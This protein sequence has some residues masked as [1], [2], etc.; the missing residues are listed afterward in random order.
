MSGKKREK[1]QYPGVFFRKEKDG[2]KAFYILYRKGGRESKLIEEPVG[3]SSTGMTPAKAKNIRADRIR[4]IEC[5]NKENREKLKLESNSSQSI[6]NL[7]CLWDKYF[8]LNSEKSDIKKDLSLLRHVED[9]LE[10]NVEEIT[11]YDIDI[12]I[13]NLKN[14]KSS[15]SSE[16]DP[17][18]LSLSTI[19]HV[20][21]LIRRLINFGIKRNLCKKPENLSIEIPHVDNEKTEMLS[22]EEMKRYL[23]ALDEEPDQDA[24]ALIR[25][26]MVT[27]MRKGALLGLKWS[28]C[29][30]EKRTI[31]LQGEYAKKGRTEYIPMNDSAK[32][33]LESINNRNSEYVFPG[34]DGKKRNDYRRIARRV[35]KKAG[36]PEDFRPLHGLRHNFASTLASSGEVELYIIQKLL[37]H[38]SPQMTQRYAHLRDEALMEASNKFTETFKK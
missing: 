35:K 19:A 21:E 32:I 16:D 2:T 4:G 15:R 36:L 33:I 14:K 31:C 18:N 7:K 28:D 26:A 38:S 8:D 11:T 1:T 3:K 17:H 25:L 9:L 30:F 20:L 23:Q 6:I 27:G 37:T 13:K 24:V 22:D 5:S 12:L 34:K 29:N 10:K